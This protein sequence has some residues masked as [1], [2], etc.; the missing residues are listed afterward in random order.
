MDCVVQIQLHS[1]WSRN[2][3]NSA[4]VGGLK[5]RLTKSKMAAAV[6]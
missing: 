6:I 5:N 1:V 4:V 2:E 3:V